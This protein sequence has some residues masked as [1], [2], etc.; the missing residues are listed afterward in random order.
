MFGNE[1]AVA[2][3]RL[4]ALSRRC[5]EAFI[6]LT[7]GLTGSPQV[8]VRSRGSTAARS[9]TS[10]G[11]KDGLSRARGRHHGRPLLRLFRQRCALRP[12]QLI[13]RYREQAPLCLGGTVRLP[14]RTGRLPACGDGPQGRSSELAPACATPA[15]K[16]SRPSHER[17]RN[18]PEPFSKYYVPVSMSVSGRH[19]IASLKRACARVPRIR[20]YRDEALSSNQAI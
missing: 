20:H 2:D 12:A 7:E 16:S 1:G 11:D 6:E 18:N 4:L 3:R 10:S 15:P 14:A 13:T 17:Y 5:G 9:T 8:T 19:Y